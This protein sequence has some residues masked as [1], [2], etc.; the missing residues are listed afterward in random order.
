M[1]RELVVAV[2]RP[3]RFGALVGALAVQRIAFYCGPGQ[4]SAELSRIRWF[5][6]WRSPGLDTAGRTLLLIAPLFRCI[7]DF[8]HRREAAAEVALIGS[9]RRWLPSAPLLAPERNSRATGSWLPE[10][11][12]LAPSETNIHR[13]LNS[14]LDR[15][16]RFLR[17]V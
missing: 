8:Q 15:G 7:G 1:L 11:I 3:R 13:A 12:V 9:R 17:I 6:R 10:A 16:D 2:R 4:L 5:A 14:P